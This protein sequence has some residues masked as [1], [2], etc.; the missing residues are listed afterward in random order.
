MKAGFDGTETASKKTHEEQSQVMDGP[1]L[2]LKDVPVLCASARFCHRDGGTWELTHHSD[3]A[4]ARELAIVESCQCPSGRLIEFDK[5]TG[6]AFEK[7]VEKSSQ[8][9]L[10]S[11]A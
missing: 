11:G 1:T 5:K 9:L 3:K 6:K 7:E 8:P 4:D 10:F 2:K